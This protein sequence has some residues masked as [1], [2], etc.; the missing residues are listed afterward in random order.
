VGRKSG[1][2]YTDRQDGVQRSVSEEVEP[3]F[4]VSAC[5]VALN[6]AQA[7]EWVELIPAGKFTAVDGRGPFD[8]HDPELIVTSSLAKMPLVGLVIDYDHSTDLAAPEGRPA[9]AAGW[10][11]EFKVE[12]GAIFARVEWTTDAAE[13]LKT[14]KYRYVSP[15]FEHSK[16]GK[17]ER[18]LR[19]A[20]TNNPALINLPAIA[21]AQAAQAHAKAQAAR[22]EQVKTMARKDGEP[23]LSE[24]MATLEQTYPDADL[25]KLMKAASILMGDDYEGEEEEDEEQ[26]A[27]ADG[28][29]EYET[30]E[31]MASRQAE[32]MARC[33]SDSDKAEIVKKH[34]AEK[35]RFARRMRPPKT[36]SA[37]NA[38]G[39]GARESATW[40]MNQPA[41]KLQRQWQSIR[42]S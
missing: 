38:S 17:V 29:F 30:A 23:K 7:Q 3:N 42:W 6:A 37:E 16:D 18:I 32:E 33:S 36:A 26:A 31:Q 41:K 21:S 22:N 5:A 40:V 9:P 2:A 19:A 8:N 35:E 28:P 34:E 24:I 20:L 11:R 25:R 13:A 27:A 39:S 12:R 4:L 1:V 14:K 15:V 10:F